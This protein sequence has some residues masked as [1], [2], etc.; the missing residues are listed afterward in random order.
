MRSNPARLFLFAALA[1]VL[2]AALLSSPANAADTYI[3]T[4]RPGADAGTLAVSTGVKAGN[5]T[6]IRC[7]GFA[8]T[9]K[10]CETA[11]TSCSATT[12][13]SR[14]D[15]D[16]SIDICGV[17]GYSKLS[18]FRTYDGGVPLCRLYNV[19]PSSPACRQ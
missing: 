7:D 10:L 14:I 2:K 13:D 5:Q 18:L 1:V 16:Q 11:V 4:L 17:S 15:A 6:M 12:N 9:Y 8:V 19:N 3:E